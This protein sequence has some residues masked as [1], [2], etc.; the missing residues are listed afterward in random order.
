MTEP[1]EKPT[2]NLVGNDGNAFSIIGRVKE[3]LRK[4]GADEEYVM[5]YQVEAT[6]GNYD[7]LLVVTMGYVHVM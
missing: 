1:R 7:H 2:V 4:A 3:A 5:K 6:S